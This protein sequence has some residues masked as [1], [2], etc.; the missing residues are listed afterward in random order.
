MERDGIAV[1]VTHPLWDIYDRKGLLAKAKAKV[2][3]QTSA[4]AVFIDTFNLARRPGWCHMEVG[5]KRT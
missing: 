2:T 5:R 3:A 1:I 4:E